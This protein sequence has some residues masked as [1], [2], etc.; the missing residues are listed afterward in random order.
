MGPVHCVCCL[1]SSFA[2][3]PVP[4]TVSSVAASGSIGRPLVAAVAA[5]S[6]RCL[7]HRSP[8]SAVAAIRLHRW[9]CRSPAFAVLLPLLRGLGVLVCPS[10]PKLQRSVAWLPR[11]R[12]TGKQALF[13]ICCNSGA[14]AQILPQPSV[15]SAASPH[16][17]GPLASSLQSCLEA[18]RTSARAE[19][20]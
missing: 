18:S 9:A 13:H 3:G 14:L 2:G 5:H 15:P 20:S 1:L 4:L 11:L 12:I 8:V 6:L 17:L 7:V 16:L 10:G 19:V